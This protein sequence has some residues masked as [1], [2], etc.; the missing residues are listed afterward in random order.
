MATS[1]SLMLD[2]EEKNEVM[3]KIDK[4]KTKSIE[5]PVIF[6]FLLITFIQMKLSNIK[7]QKSLNKS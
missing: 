3:R 4:N 5:A 7:F 6:R 1:S 2:N